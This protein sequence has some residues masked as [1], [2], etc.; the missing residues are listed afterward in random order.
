LRLEVL[1]DGRPPEAG[2]G[3]FLERLF[4]WFD[5]DGDGSLSREEAARIFPLPLPGGK[6]LAVDF[7]RLDVDQDG[8]ASRKEL[9]A[10]C[11]RHGFGPVVAVV[12]PPSAEDTRLADL[13]LRHL[14][15]GKLTRADWR[16]AP[17]LLRKFDLN[18]DEFLEP[19]E[20]LGSPSHGLLSEAALVKLGQAGQERD[21][22]LRLDVG[23]KLRAPEFEGQQ[24]GTIHL[25]PAAEPGGLHRLY[26]PGGRWAIGF[27]T[28]RSVADVAS[29]G[30]FLVAQFKAALGDR[31]ALGMSDLEADSG[32][33]GL[34]ELFAY[35]DRDGDG[36]LTL[37][38]LE[39]YLR[40]VELGV[41]AQVWV[42]VAD[43]ARNPFP[44]LDGDGDGRLSY[45]ELSRAVD[46]MQPERVETSGLPLQIQLAF[47]SAPVKFLGGVPI[48]TM[49]RR[50]RPA[51]ANAGSAPRWFRAMDRNGDGVVS[52]QEFVGP[53]EAFRKLDLNGDGVITA[54]EA[55]R[56]AHK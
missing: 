48:P 25:V 8:K 10:Y 19:A 44:F 35:A 16:R 2:W 31:R 21:S 40:L 5:R 38:E 39:S 32:L 28:T 13:F 24:A 20:L 42:C 14:G 51:P 6:A 30:E 34:R 56:A 26:G 3:A 52:P 55:A 36:R 41:Q 1:V 43:R 54:D 4:D 18:E 33:S 22:L 46:V 50:P 27:R 9:K 23:T 29:A 12:E 45:R 53:P 7:A 15:N 37:D 47:G 17:T 49:T 11:R